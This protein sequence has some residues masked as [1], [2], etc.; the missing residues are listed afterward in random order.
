MAPFQRQLLHWQDAQ[1]LPK[2]DRRS[3]PTLRAEMLD[4][5]IDD[6]RIQLIYGGQD[7]KPIKKDPVEMVK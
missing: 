2:L 4:C 3:S 1:D 7:G 5:M 6:P